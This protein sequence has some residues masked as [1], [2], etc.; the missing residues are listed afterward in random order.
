MNSVEPAHGD[1]VLRDTLDIPIVP[2][3]VAL[4]PADATAGWTARTPV[5]SAARDGRERISEASPSR[6]EQLRS[7]C[8]YANGHGCRSVADRRSPL[9][10]PVQAGALPGSSSWPTRT[11]VST[12]LR[13]EAG[14]GR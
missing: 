5:A 9:S 7:G 1:S 10:V 14:F 12:T 6:T 8:A 11:I 2:A 3:I 4:R 13:R